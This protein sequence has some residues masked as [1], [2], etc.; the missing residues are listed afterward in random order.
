[1]LNNAV[2]GAVTHEVFPVAGSQSDAFPVNLDDMEVATQ[3]KRVAVAC[4]ERPVSPARREPA[5]LA[6]YAVTELTPPA[7]GCL[8]MAVTTGTL[9]TKSVSR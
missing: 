8:G 6:S 2:A 5:R 1:M 7:P 9:V 3:T 4:E